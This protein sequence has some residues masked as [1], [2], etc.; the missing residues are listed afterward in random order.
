MGL[1]ATQPGITLLKLLEWQ[2]NPDEIYSLITS[3]QL[4]V[5]LSAAD[6][7]SE[8]EKVRL[9]LSSE[10]ADSTP[11]LIESGN[12]GE[13]YPQSQGLIEPTIGSQ[14]VWDG[15]DWVVLNL[16]KREVTLLNSEQKVVNLPIKVFEELLMLMYED[17][18][19]N[20]FLSITVFFRAARNER[21]N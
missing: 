20:V 10:T 19:L 14:I 2:L 8:A 4:Y 13:H 15:I 3:Q 11:Q 17:N 12:L 6:L 1:V 7:A 18:G 21:F 5:D 16:G 9:F